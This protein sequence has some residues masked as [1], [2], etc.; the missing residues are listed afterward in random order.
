MTRRC[1]YFAC[2][3]PTAASAAGFYFCDFH[4]EALLVLC[5]AT[6]EPGE[7]LAAVGYCLSALNPKAFRLEHLEL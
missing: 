6:E 7:E 1:D 3:E 4:Q 5:E 2:E